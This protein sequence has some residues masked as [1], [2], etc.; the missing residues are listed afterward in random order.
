MDGIWV[1][2]DLNEF[3]K[4]HCTLHAFNMPYITILTT[5]TS[6]RLLSPEHRGTKL[7]ISFN[8]YALFQNSPYQSEPKSS[9]PKG[10]P[11][12]VVSISST[13]PAIA[14]GVGRILCKPTGSFILSAMD[15]NFLFK[16]QKAESMILTVTPISGMSAHL[17]QL[18][19][20]ACYLL[21]MIPEQS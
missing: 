9:L 7:E 20:L 15:L 8:N 1:W 21:L 10:A 4:I 14:N 5:R 17:L 3:L 2:Q 18:F 16:F 12:E 19:Q 13:Q 11:V 6:S